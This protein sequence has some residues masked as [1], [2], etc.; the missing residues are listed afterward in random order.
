MSKLTSTLLLTV[1][2]SVA[3]ASSSSP[4]TMI[5]SVQ[6]PGQNFTQYV[7][8]SATPLDQ[9][10]NDIS[11]CDAHVHVQGTCLLSGGGK[12]SLTAVCNDALGEIVFSI[13]AGSH[14]CTGAVQHSTQLVD[15][16]EELGGGKEFIK[17][18]CAKQQYM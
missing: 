3:A 18:E 10:T 16:C 13:Y 12:A 8:Q 11:S 14:N 6:L 9:C 1:A 15:V 2:S 17:M 4:L 5:D 7:C